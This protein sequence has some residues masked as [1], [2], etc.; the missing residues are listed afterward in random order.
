MAFMLKHSVLSAN[1]RWVTRT[2]PAAARIRV[3]LIATDRRRDA[4]RAEGCR[5][6]AGAGGICCHESITSRRWG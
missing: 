4:E 2:G 1:G 6:A 3:T 5:T